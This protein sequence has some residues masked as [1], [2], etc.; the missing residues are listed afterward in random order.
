[1]A[2]A[3]LNSFTLALGEIT[4]RSYGGGVLTFEPGEIRKL[5]IP[6][7]GADR[8]DLEQID[9]WIREDKIYETLDYTDQ[10]LLKEGLGLSDREIVLL[11]GIWEKLRDRRI[12]RKE[13][14]KN[15]NPSAKAKADG[16]KPPGKTEP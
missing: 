12:Y 7:T 14:R 4:G 11:R 9:R 2:A 13:N 10:I 3:F 16:Q 5:K 15:G 8:L 1:M 6:M